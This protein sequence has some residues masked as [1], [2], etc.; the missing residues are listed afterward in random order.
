MHIL[1][2][3][4]TALRLTRDGRTVAEAPGY[5]LLER[6]R[7]TLGTAARAQARLAP[8]QT[9]TQFWSRLSMDTLP[10][11]S[12]RARTHADLAYAQLLDLWEQAGAPGD[13]ND[14]IFAVPGSLDRQQL[15]LL[16]G[17]VREC[18]FRAAGLVDL[19]VAALAGCETAP[20]SHLIHVDV[21]LHRTLLTSLRIEADQ[22]SRTRVEEVPSAAL[23]GLQD[24]MV[25]LI[26]DEFIRE[27][28]FDPLHEA[29]TE[30][31][32]HDALPQWLQA[33]AQQ[34]ET[35][36]ELETA[37]NT[38]RIT[39][40]EDQLRKRLA[41][42]YQQVLER[43]QSMLQGDMD[44][45]LLIAPG[46]DA[47]PGLR[48]LLEERLQLRCQLLDNDAVSRGALAHAA[49]LA[50]DGDQL[51][52]VTR[53]P[54][55]PLRRTEPSPA[56]KQLPDHQTPGETQPSSPIAESATAPHG[57]T[58]ARTY[59]P[60]P[61]TA[62]PTRAPDSVQQQAATH[63]L[64]GH[65][66]LPLV[67]GEALFLDQAGQPCTRGSEAACRVRAQATGCRLDPLTEGTVSYL[68]RTVAAPLYLEPGEEVLL[69]E[70]VRVAPIIVLAADPIVEQTQG[71][72]R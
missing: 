1:E 27:T 43:V 57:A 42:R 8:R 14:V 60:S 21:H 18:P 47:Q 24:T 5:A 19:A 12:S 64:A 58:E 22:V 45:A 11:T 48:V 71:A 67:A 40:H 41:P 63:L 4:D 39:L 55:P 3:N 59:S 34:G 15:A 7:L 65:M 29:R 52:F 54:A 72:G 61:A 26:A 37:R 23:T 32:L 46:A 2:L 16:L 20:H 56:T 31:Q 33:L 68:G 13:D 25:G 10:Q 35:L 62:T 44:A 69:C 30:Q 6:N 51:A 66:A 17:V 9:Q 36:L 49:L 70:Q 38:F 53:L 50:G 28:R